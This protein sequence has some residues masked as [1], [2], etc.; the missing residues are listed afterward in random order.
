MGVLLH[1]HGVT[2]R[3]LLYSQCCEPLF[4]VEAGAE[5]GDGAGVRP[6]LPDGHAAETVVQLLDRP[7]RT[8]E[9]AVHIVT[10]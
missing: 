5:R 1:H 3:L 6:P 2:V 8:G 4:C 9:R 10:G 7:I